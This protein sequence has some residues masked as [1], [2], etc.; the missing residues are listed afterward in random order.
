MKIC[1]IFIHITDSLRFFTIPI[2]ISELYLIEKDKILSNFSK[3]LYQY[4]IGLFLFVAIVIRSDI[5]FII[6]HLSRFNQQLGP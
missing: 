3:M 5:A 1:N 2:E 4:K 6:F